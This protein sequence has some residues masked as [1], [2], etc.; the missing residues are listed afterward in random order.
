[1]PSPMKTFLSRLLLLYTLL[2]AAILAGCA[3]RPTPALFDFGPLPSAITPQP[4][5]P[6][7]LADTEAP[8]WVDSNAMFYRL[9]YANARQP[10]PYAGS[11]WAM[12]PPQLLNQRLK[13]RIAQAG[14]V[15]LSIT[16]GV[17]NVPLLRTDI[18]EF[19]Q[20]FSD[21]THSSGRVVLRASVLNGRTLLAQKS[22]MR[23]VPASSADAAGGAKALA[24]AS[25]AVITDLMTWLAGLPL[26]K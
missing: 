24:E 2:A 8:A 4:L 14:G 22:F 18:D 1:M 26:K 23:Q 19:I 13:A 16:D 25:D 6:I 3:S 10:R 15:A 12:T 11:R 21:A 7:S 20:N 9:G 5:P 17:G